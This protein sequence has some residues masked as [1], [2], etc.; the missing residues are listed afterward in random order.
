MSKFVHIVIFLSCIYIEI[1]ANLMIEGIYCGKQNCYEVLGV[2]RSS[3]KSEISKAYRALAKKHHPDKARSEEDKA[4]ASEIFKQVA[5]AYEI[6]KD[7]ESRND[8]DYMLDNPEEYYRHYYRYYRRHMTPKVDVRLVIGVTIAIVSFIQYFTA[9]QRYHDA[10]THLATNTKYRNKALIMAQEQGLY[11]EKKKVRGKS[12]S[13]LK[14]EKEAAIMKVLQD[15]LDIRGGYAKPSVTDILVI[16]LIIFPYTLCKYLFWYARWIYKFRVCNEEYGNEEKYY[17]IR[18][19]LNHSQAQFDSLEDDEKLEFLK[20]ELWKK[21][22][23][24]VWKAK[25]EEEMKIKM[26]DNS[27]F[28]MYR[29]YMKQHGPGR[30]TFDDS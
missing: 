10:I 25:K 11:D 19:Y 6:L 7:E 16:Q 23:F 20:L 24:D 14:A 4:K 21:D 30:M 3:V 15:N 13:D 2:T 28:K 5:N 22:K 26:A 1:E 17:L 29:R 9:S 12:K 8:Y 27:K 18:K